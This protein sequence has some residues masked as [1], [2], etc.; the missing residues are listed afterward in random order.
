MMSDNKTI[1]CEVIRD[2]FPS[3]IDGL[4]N[5]VTNREIEAHNADCAD[6]AA[7]LASM[8]NPQVE[9]KNISSPPVIPPNQG[10]N[11]TPKTT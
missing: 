8:K 5:E 2:L 6:C 11:A 9:P 1:P 4:T 10:I 3:Y 7:I